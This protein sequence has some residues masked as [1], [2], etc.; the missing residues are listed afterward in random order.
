M[1]KIWTFINYL[2]TV[3]LWNPIR[4]LSGFLSF[5]VF[6][7]C[8]IGLVAI[9]KRQSLN[10]EKL[11]ANLR[12][13]CKFKHYYHNSWTWYNHTPFGPWSVLNNN[14]YSN[15]DSLYMK[16]LWSSSNAWHRIAFFVPNLAL[17]SSVHNELHITRTPI[18][19]LPWT[20]WLY[21]LNQMLLLKFYSVI[22]AAKTLTIWMNGP[23]AFK[24]QWSTR[25]FFQNL[26]K[27]R[28]KY[29]VGH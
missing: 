18:K 10:G 7:L 22:S 5:S 27:S 12:H 25:N 8:F 3:K 23:P 24:R 9:A 28:R 21:T 19:S 14:V 20:N 17:W 6:I 11:K 2:W 4:S 26:L 16:V 1:W 15:L 29:F 13:W